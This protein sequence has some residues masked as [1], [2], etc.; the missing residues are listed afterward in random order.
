[1]YPNPCFASGRT[2]T[3]NLLVVGTSCCRTRIG[4]YKTDNQKNAGGKECGARIISEIRMPHNEVPMAVP[5][6]AA[7][8]KSPFEKSVEEGRFA[9]SAY[10]IGTSR[11]SPSFCR[12]LTLYL[13]WCKTKSI[14]SIRIETLCRSFKKWASLCRRGFRSEAAAGRNPCSAILNLPKSPWRTARR[15]LRL[16]CVGICSGMSPRFPD[17]ATR[18]TLK[19]IRRFLTLSCRIRT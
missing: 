1:M 19:R 8:K 10:Q 6:L 5:K 3:T 17:Q 9:R 11:N 15:S 2:S 14:L 18:L 12:R 16:C 13:R 4:K 7:V